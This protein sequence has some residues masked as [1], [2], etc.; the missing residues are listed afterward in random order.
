MIGRLQRQRKRMDEEEKRRLE[1]YPDES[2]HAESSMISFWTCRCG[3]AN[4]LV[5]DETTSFGRCSDCGAL[6]PLSFVQWRREPVI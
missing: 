6:T 4:A 3:A 5:L 2:E 1:L